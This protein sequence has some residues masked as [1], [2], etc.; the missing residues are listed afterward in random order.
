MYIIFLNFIILLTDRFLSTCC[1]GVPDVVWNTCAG[2]NMILYFA[3]SIYTTGAGTGVYTF[4]S[5]A[6]FVGGAVRVNN[7]FRTACNIWISEVFRD[8]AA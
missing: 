1:K 3:Y 8:A 4:V 2:W 5:L 6:C 7:T